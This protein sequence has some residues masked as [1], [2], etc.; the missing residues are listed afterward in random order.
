MRKRSILIPS[1]VAGAVGTTAFLLKDEQKRDRVKQGIDRTV[2][3]VKGR[4]EEDE[5][6]EL[7]KKIGHSEPYDFRDNEMVSEGAM[8]SVNHF[9]KAQEENEE[10]LHTTHE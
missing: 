3:K 7:N 2:A 8:Y 9:N 10:P 6:E 1:L 4:T 5:N